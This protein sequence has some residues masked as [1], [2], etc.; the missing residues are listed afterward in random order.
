MSNLATVTPIRPTLA[1]VERQV[2]DLDDGFIMIAMR[3]YEELIGANLTRNQA[4][5][6]H[7]VCRK[8]YGFKKKMDRI[9]DSQLAEIARISRSK[10]NI[11]KNEL[12]SMKVL[13]SE[14]GKIGPNKNIDEWVIPECSQIGNFVSKSGT[15]NVSKPDTQDVPALGAHKRN[16]LN[17]KDNTPLPPQGE[18]EGQAEQESKKR[19]PTI[20]YQAFL[21]AYNDILGDRLPNARDLTDKRRRA[22]KQLLPRLKTPNVDGF[23]AYLSAFSRMA[24]S[25]YFG[26]SK[27]GW[28]ADFDFMLRETTLV[29]VREGKFAE[30]EVAE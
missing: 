22:I 4:K 24:R 2:A 19:A 15:K 3:L 6:A 10:A 7:A 8:T 29:G 23:R 28:R 16:T 1:V 13:I 9:A 17:I 27:S 5:V 11:A 25:Y 30:R 21:D 12:I 18:E 14:A 26:D 20:P